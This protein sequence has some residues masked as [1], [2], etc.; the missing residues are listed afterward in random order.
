MLYRFDQFELDTKQFS[1]R[2]HGDEIHIEPLVFNLLCLFVENGGKVLPRDAIIERVWK[3][4]FVSDAAVSSCVKAVRKALGDS[5]DNQRFIRTV[6]GRGFSFTAPVARVAGALETSTSRG[7]QEETQ[8]GSPVSKPAAPPKIA[9]LPLFPLSQDPQVGLLGDAVAQEIILELSRLHWLFVIAR[10]SSFQFR[11][12]EVDLAQ[13][14]R[15]LGARYFLTGT[16]MKEAHNCILALELCSAPDNAVIWADRLITPLQDLMH[17]RSTVTGKIA[18]VLETRIQLSEA[19]QTAKIPTENLDAWASYHRGLQ[20][21]YR[22]T[23]HDNELA[24]QLFAQSLNI[25][26]GFARAH[27]GLSFTHFQNA[28]LG[29]T[30]DRC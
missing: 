2:S 8:T 3:G 5:G 18:A 10:G 12:Q 15:I 9:V 20:H 13:A 6:R 16:I 7:D 22:F 24:A 23:K 14:S 30:S 29:F 25:D 11:G 17:M 28:F 1:L 27:A 21:M 19:L 26:P 4:R